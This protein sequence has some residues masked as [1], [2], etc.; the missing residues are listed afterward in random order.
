V[1]TATVTPAPGANDATP[2]NNTATDTD[3][4]GASQTDLAISKTDGQT[5]YV[6]GTPIS[7]TIVVTN[8]GPSTATG[9]SVADTV[10]AAI[11]G[12]SVT[13]AVTGAG[14]CGTNASSGSTVSFTGLKLDPGAGNQLTITVSGMVGASASGSLLNTATVTAGAG[15]VDPNAGNNTASDTD[16]A[17]TA[18][19]DL[20]IAKTDGQATYVPGTPISYTLTVTNAGPSDAGGVIITD[21]VPAAITG[22]TVACVASGTA[23][24]GTNGTAGNAIAF[25]NATVA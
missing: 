24:C 6:P 11:T 15:A 4:A 16:T 9:I 23:A 21:A 20:A 2:A 12:V 17:G 1:I 14:D 3:I 22:V 13:C 18:Q 8:A 10:P 19:V 7:Y 5:T 25:T